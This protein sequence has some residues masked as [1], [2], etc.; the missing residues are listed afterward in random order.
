MIIEC[1]VLQAIYCATDVIIYY[2]VS[3]YASL[4]QLCMLRVSIK[5]MQSI[6]SLVKLIYSP[7]I[8]AYPYFFITMQAFFLSVVH[9][10]VP[11]YNYATHKHGNFNKTFTQQDIK[12]AI[13]D[14]LTKTQAT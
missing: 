6:V 9:H 10:F 8:H 1:R 7:S 11:D 14:I 3:F 5:S 13:E 12:N 2:Y 4:C